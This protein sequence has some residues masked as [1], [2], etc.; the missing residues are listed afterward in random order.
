MKYTVTA[1]Y[2]LETHTLWQSSTIATGPGGPSGRLL[3]VDVHV[4]RMA[5]ETNP[6]LLLPLLCHLRRETKRTV[7]IRDQ[8]L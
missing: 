3:G 5:K 8:Y 2:I 1:V 4:R 6:L 7:S